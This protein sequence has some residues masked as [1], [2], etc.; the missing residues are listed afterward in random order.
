M[1][2][3]DLILLILFFVGV[4]L[5]WFATWKG[6][7]RKLV[8]GLAIALIIGAG[9]GMRGVYPE[10]ALPFVLFLGGGG[11]MWLSY[12]CMKSRDTRYEKFVMPLIIVGAL[13][14]LVSS[15]WLKVNRSERKLI[16]T[17][18]KNPL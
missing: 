1:A 15:S 4:V 12:Y 5:L 6:Q 11:L 16:N 14:L 3:L 9:L 17:P 7:L 18:L 10:D 13:L 8:L 2:T